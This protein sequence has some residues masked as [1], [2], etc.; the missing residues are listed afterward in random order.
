M[1]LEEA[2]FSQVNTASGKAPSAPGWVGGSAASSDV[3]CQWKQEFGQRYCFW[4][5]RLFHRLIRCRKEDTWW[6]TN[7]PIYKMQTYLIPFLVRTWS[8]PAPHPSSPHASCPPTCCW[9][10]LPHLL[11]PA[12]TR[13]SFDFLD[14]I[15]FLFL[16]FPERS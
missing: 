10:G 4:Y 9:H 12:E 8:A 2:N 14:L 11:F 15:S 13:K 6:D 16:S 7:Q 1:F 3:L 5:L